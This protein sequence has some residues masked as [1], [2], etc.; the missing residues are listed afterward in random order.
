MFNVKQLKMNE[1]MKY[2]WQLIIST[3]NAT[4]EIPSLSPWFIKYQKI[5]LVLYY[6]KNSANSLAMIAQF[7]QMSLYEIS[8]LFC[9][10]MLLRKLNKSHW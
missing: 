1:F 5:I 4:L 3:S 6:C 10:N 2:I 9:Q 8:M 7:L